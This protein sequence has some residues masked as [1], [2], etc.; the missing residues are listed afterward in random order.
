MRAAHSF[1]FVYIWY[2]T[3]LLILLLT[4]KESKKQLISCTVKFVSISLYNLSKH[5]RRPSYSCQTAALKAPLYNI[6]LLELSFDFSFTSLTSIWLLVG[7]GLL[8]RCSGGSSCYLRELA[9]NSWAS[10]L[11]TWTCVV[12]ISFAA[13]TYT[14]NQITTTI[15]VWSHMGFVVV[16]VYVCVLEILL[17]CLFKCYTHAAE[18]SATS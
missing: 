13:S 8:D 17:P 14:A 18:E 6:R 16:D 9:P 11:K 3:C 5:Y 7:G 10:R 12:A 15:I 2:S 4:T 1:W